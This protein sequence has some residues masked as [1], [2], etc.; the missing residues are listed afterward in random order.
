MGT[1]AGERENCTGYPHQLYPQSFCVVSSFPTCVQLTH[2]D[3]VTFPKASS[4]GVWLARTHIVTDPTWPGIG[5]ILPQ[6]GPGLPFHPDLL[7]HAPDTQRILKQLFSSVFCTLWLL[8]LPI[9]TPSSLLVFLSSSVLSISTSITL[10]G[11]FQKPESLS[12][13]CEFSVT[14]CDSVS[15]LGLLLAPKDTRGN[16][17]QQ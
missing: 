11:L 9:Q 12:D 13:G 3:P 6:Q 15:S 8:S 14:L 10:N 17:L 1:Y 2:P 4:E 5:G 16:A 7:L